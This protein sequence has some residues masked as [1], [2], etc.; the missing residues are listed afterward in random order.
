MGRCLKDHHHW[1]EGHPL[2]LA[3]GAVSGG[4]DKSLVDLLK[5][6]DQMMYKE[7]SRSRKAK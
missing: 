6:A 5:K 2:S 4:K 1:Y 7:K 3:I